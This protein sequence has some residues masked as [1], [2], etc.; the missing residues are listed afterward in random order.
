MVVQ[1]SCYEE[2]S[3]TPFLINSCDYADIVTLAPH[4]A[5]S[6]GLSILSDVASTPKTLNASSSGPAS[7]TR[8]NFRV[9]GSTS[10]AKML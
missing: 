5:T 1:H 3:T 4:P 10:A 7:R 2:S 8:R 6:S 9:G